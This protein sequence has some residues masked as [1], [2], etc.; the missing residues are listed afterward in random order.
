MSTLANRLRQHSAV[1]NVSTVSLHKAA[2][3]VGQVAAVA[4]IP[5]L[6]GAED[7]GYF[8]FFLSWVYL[9]Q[10]LGDLGTPE[11]MSR[12]VPTLSLAETKRLYGR[13]LL[14]KAVAGLLCGLIGFGGALL[15]APWMRLDWALLI[16]LGTALHVVAWVPFNLLLGVNQ[17]GFW[18]VE[19][20]WRQWV[21]LLLIIPFYPLL[22]LGGTVWAWGLMEA[23]FTV[24]GLWW[25]RAYWEPASF[26]WDWDYLWPYLKFGFGFAV[27][28]LISALLYRSGPV[29]VETLTRQTAA[30]GFMNLAIGLFLMPYLGLT[31]I[32]FSFVPTLS[33][34]YAQGRLKQMQQWVQNFVV[35]GWFLG[36]LGVLVVWLL[37]DWGVVVVFGSDYG[38]AAAPLKWIS[39]G[40]PLAALLW[41][42]YLV[43]M[44]TG[45]GSLRL[46]TSVAAL[47][48]FLALAFWL[49][50]SLGAS[51]VAIAMTA[52]LAVNFVVLYI[53]LRPIFSLHW[54]MLGVSGLAAAGGIWVIIY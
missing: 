12:F 41:G 2:Q 27:A 15:L 23:L 7:H 10:I 52:S 33:N 36:W 46:W 43:A 6:L 5:R 42:A 37:A 13:T 45:R 14:F 20:A 48:S 31:Q 21:L 44:V 49:V 39:L 38:P 25:A 17:V 51:G 35:V 16:S 30:A 9:A 4:I 47:G 32:A 29:L 26:A 34:L 18:M 19:Q 1:R 22:G 50:P 24:L 53:F 11:V 3:L 28:N 40:F 54:G 8:A